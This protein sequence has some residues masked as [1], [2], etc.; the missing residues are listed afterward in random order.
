MSTDYVFDGTDPA[1]SPSDRPNPLNRYGR[2][3]LQGEQ[4]VLKTAPAPCVLRVPVLYGQV[5]SLDE[6]PVTL[7]ATRL[8]KEQPRTF[9]NWAV[10][11]PTHVD[12]VAEALARILELRQERP[13]FSGVVH[14]SGNEALTKYDMALAMAELLGTPRE[15]VVPDNSPPAGA[16]RP[17][18]THLDCSDLEKLGISRRTPFREG[19]TRALKQFF[20]F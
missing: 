15:L 9:D 10:R 2:S 13:D 17:Q 4:E 12:D 11:Y 3:K 5:E 8:G 14:W 19:V 20:S 16:P 7:L 6:S 1:Y 18:N